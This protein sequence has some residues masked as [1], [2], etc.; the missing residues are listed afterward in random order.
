MT[1]EHEGHTGTTPA[2]G[3]ET[4]AKTGGAPTD[5][6]GAVR[7]TVEAAG[8]TGTPA[9]ESAPATDNAPVIETAPV[10]EIAPAMENASTTAAAT[11]ALALSPSSGTAA[12][13]PDG[14]GATPLDNARL[15]DALEAIKTGIV[16]LVVIQILTILSP[17]LRT[18]LK[19]TLIVGVLLV[20]G[21]LAVAAVAYRKALRAQRGIPE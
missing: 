2:T 12:N 3:A 21:G 5:A 11:T 16:W 17:L 15:R 13:A 9:T 7:E 1:D 14:G 18:S 19:W 10:T 6:A 8:S 4:E 20:A